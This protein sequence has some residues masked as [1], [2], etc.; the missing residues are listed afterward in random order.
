MIFLRKNWKIG[1]LLLWVLILNGCKSHSPKI[2]T[3]FLDLS[4]WDFKTQSINLD[5][6]WEFYWKQLLTP[7]DF[8]SEPGPECDYIP[9]PRA[10]KGY[11][12][13]KEKLGPYGYATYRATIKA[14]PGRY[15]LLT[16]KIETAFTIWV[17]GQKLSSVGVVGKDR[18][19]AKPQYLNSMEFF[20][21]K[22]DRIE[23]IIQ[24]SNF[25]HFQSGIVRTIT[26]GNPKSIYSRALNRSALNFSIAGTFMLAALYNLIIFMRRPQIRATLFFAIFYFCFAAYIM[27]LIE[28][29]HIRLFPNFNWEIHFKILYFT[30][31]YAV[32]LYLFYLKELFP[33]NANRKI[34]KGLWVG[35]SI[36]AVIIL[37]TK[38]AVHS[39]IAG[40]LY[41]V[42]VL[43][44]LYCGHILF[45]ALKNK[46]KGAIA[47]S[48]PWLVLFITVVNDTL[49]SSGVID[50]L[51]LTPFGILLFAI[52]QIC[53]MADAFAESLTQTERLSDNLAK[54]NI[55]F[56]SLLEECDVEVGK[57]LAKLNQIIYIKSNGHFCLIFQDN[58]AKPL[59]LNMQIGKIPT[60]IRDTQ[61]L[62]VHRSYLLNLEKIRKIVK[63][64][65]NKYEALIKGTDDR[66]PVSRNK[67][68]G[69]RKAYPNLFN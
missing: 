39:R 53:Y 22:E 65:D 6:E 34:V 49:Y 18:D 55:K 63:V 33:D 3:G 56:A 41:L 38:A 23:I 66:I 62:D 47:Q 4:G 44:A 13:N 48:I 12:L 50:T 16:S 20:W 35:T 31:I 25:R 46:Q 61:F 32:I 7:A 67:V 59:E 36:I 15:A 26:L 11:R 17:N 19:S 57:I 29:L 30:F 8:E 68:S 21:V 28:R 51:R 40:I 10:W 5:G 37:L 2:E 9:V 43:S 45:N 60:S 27:L 58:G 14:P 24:V 52:W 42:L 64:A 1:Y 69:L 54:A